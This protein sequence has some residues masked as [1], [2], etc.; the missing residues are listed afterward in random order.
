MREKIEECM[1]YILARDFLDFMVGK[2]KNMREIC[3]LD[4][5]KLTYHV[6]ERVLVECPMDEIRGDLERY[7]ATT[8]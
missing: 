1:G 8:Q 4:I 6:S 2:R 5:L 7:L 3:G